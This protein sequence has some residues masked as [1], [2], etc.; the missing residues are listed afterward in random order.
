MG[1]S[2]SGDTTNS[3]SVQ[4]LKEAV[5]RQDCNA[6]QARRWAREWISSQ[7]D[8]Q[9]M[10]SRVRERKRAREKQSTVLNQ[11]QWQTAAQ[12]APTQM[13]GQEQS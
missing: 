9:R 10:R 12:I 2:S 6:E 13:T 7:A 8:E 3:N 11:L 4:R 5:H 1:W